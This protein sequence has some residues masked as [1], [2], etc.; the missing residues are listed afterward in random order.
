MMMTGLPPSLDTPG[1]GGC[2]GREAE[3]GGGYIIRVMRKEA[4]FSG[5][6]RQNEQ[7]G[8]PR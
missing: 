3:R 4:I 7:N 5:P 6:G 8:Q 1:K 2:G